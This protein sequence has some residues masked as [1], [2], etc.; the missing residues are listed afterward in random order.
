MAN[1]IQESS[2]GNKI[3]TWLTDAA[4]T[5]KQVSVNER[6]PGMQITYLNPDKGW[7]NEQYV[8]TSTKDANWSKD[9]NWI[10]VNHSNDINSIKNFNNRISLKDKLIKG[11]YNKSL[12]GQL[13]LGDGSFN[14]S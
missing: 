6:K 9:N 1:F 7:I 14:C 4:T 3:L 12:N 13:T 8:G 5:R 2:G 11:Y 10:G